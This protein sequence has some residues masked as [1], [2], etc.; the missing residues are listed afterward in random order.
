MERLGRRRRLIHQRLVGGLQ[1]AP[2]A[3]ARDRLGD[4][5]ARRR[6]QIVVRRR[7][8]ERAQVGE[9]RLRIARPDARQAQEVLRVGKL[10]VVRVPRGEGLE[11][12][13][14]VAETLLLDE[15]ARE[16][17]RRRRD[18]RVV[19]PSG[20][21]LA[22]L[23]D[24]RLGPAEL[25]VAPREAVVGVGGAR[26][27]GVLF[28]D[29]IVRGARLGEAPQAEERLGLPELRLERLRWWDRRLRAP[30]RFER[31]LD[32]AQ[33]EAR[34]TQE[35]Q[36]A[37]DPR[38][39]RVLGDEPLEHTAGERV[40]PVGE[41]ALTHQPEPLGLVQSPCGRGRERDHEQDYGRRE[42][43]P[44]ARHDDSSS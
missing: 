13:Q 44:P 10:L 23:R 31:G 25:E 36:G 9:P 26:R 2:V 8:D 41:R 24:R 35:E 33:R 5:P 22:E 43:R 14:R 38:V 27:G 15:R 1:L 29:R 17:E 3:V 18:R 19:R 11:E 30:E 20:E 28:D 4:Q 39:T 21:Q 12:R 7:H 34:A 32:V 16:L 42:E 6:R 40:E 37:P